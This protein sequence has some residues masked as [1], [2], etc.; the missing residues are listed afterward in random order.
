MRFPVTA[1]Q[2]DLLLEQERSDSSSSHVGF[3][4]EFGPAVDP[5]DIV[6]G[7]HEMVRSCPAL[8]LR[9]HG[10][11]E[12]GFE[13]EIEDYREDCVAI[14]LQDV[15]NADEAAVR[16]YIEVLLHRDA[17][18][19]D[20]GTRGVYQLVLLKNSGGRHHLVISLQQVALDRRSI[21][22]MM[23]RLVVVILDTSGKSRFLV[24]AD[25]YRHAVA[26]TQPSA[27]EAAAAARY[28]QRDLEN[29]RNAFDRH[30]RFPAARPHQGRMSIVGDDYRKLR[31]SI[32]EGGWGAA[33]VF[34]ERLLSEWQRYAPHTTL[35]DTFM[36]C[37]P[38]EFGK[39][40][41]M[42]TTVRPLIFDLSGGDWRRRTTAKLMR[43]SAYQ[44]VDSYVLRTAENACGIPRRPFPAYNFTDDSGTS[45]PQQRPA[46]V[47]VSKF[48]PRR[49][50]GRPVLVRVR[51]EGISLSIAV[52]MN[53][54]VFS[55]ADTNRLLRRLAG[56]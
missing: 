5:R 20:W 47:G 12:T 34:L 52:H 28:W 18:A 6:R 21:K 54:E 43:G 40:I 14:D 55:K 53:S 41:G 30:P 49:A 8:R 45:E 22:I 29:C 50:S 33:T 31:A 10:S 51:D 11:A 9:F 48:A 13:Q 56:G 44:G 38:E 17:V 16:H 24:E 26:A 25:R 36:T 27:A 37:R 19:W 2:A 7:V 32:P 4:L 23:D 42:F 39:Q 15:S 46:L 1:G 35:V 3:V